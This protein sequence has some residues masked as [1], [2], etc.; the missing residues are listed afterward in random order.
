MAN[1]DLTQKLTAKQ[2]AFV[3]EY[4]VDLNATQAA[5][6]AGYSKRT[7]KSVGCENLTKPNVA[8]AIAECRDARAKRTEITAD[9]VLAELARVGFADI[10]DLF[11]WDA[12]R[13]AFVPSRELTSEQAAAISAVKSETTI[14]THQD[15]TTQTKIKLALKT[16]D[17]VNA[18]REMGKHL[19]IA[20]HVRL[21]GEIGGVLRVPSLDGENADWGAT[22]KRQQERLGRISATNSGGKNGNGK[23]S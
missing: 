18:L 5:I 20:E 17:K 9:R 16:Y 13:T 12:E 1:T 10:R 6:R 11:E 4:L 21:S 7:A 2:E 15:G 14:F 19:G 3:R 8:A 23:R 22:A